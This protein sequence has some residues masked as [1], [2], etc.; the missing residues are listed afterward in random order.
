MTHILINLYGCSQNRLIDPQ[1]FDD[2]LEGGA[3]MAK[4]T[5]VNKII[6][7]IGSGN[8]FGYTG[9]MLLKESHIS[10]HGWTK[11]NHCAVDLFTCGELKADVMDLLNFIGRSFD[12]NVIYYR[13]VDR[14]VNRPSSNLDSH[15]ALWNKIILD[16]GGIRE[17]TL[18]EQIC[19]WLGFS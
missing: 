18:F 6:E 2:V 7:K 3:K 16:M 12:A 10:L 1:V 11:E 8:N 15:G 13:V 4:L 19:N 14:P 5:P 9:I 17:F